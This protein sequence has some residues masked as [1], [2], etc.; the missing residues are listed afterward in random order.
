LY[1]TSYKDRNADK[2]RVHIIKGRKLLSE[3]PSD[4][5]S[6][7][8]QGGPNL[9]NFADY[10]KN[11]DDLLNLETLNNYYFRMEKSIYMD[12]R[13]QYVISFEP[14]TNL[15]YALYYGKLYIDKESLAFTR[16]ET[17]LDMRDR[18][19]VTQAILK[20]KPMGL[21]F[22]PLE[23]SFVVD[24]KEQNGRMALSYVRNEVKFKCDWKK[25]LFHTEYTIVSEMAVT[26]MTDNDVEKISYKESFKDYNS[27]SDK[28][29][30]FYD[31]NYWGAYNII[32]P[33]ESL[34]KAVKKIARQNEKLNDNK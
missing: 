13:L 10:V 20:K 32:A 15:E 25:K 12:N 23:L 11:P 8:L 34:D 1:K 18:N 22:K 6:V 26:D 33:T 21:N 30:S 29:S 9:S 2:D 3:K 27:L 17:S 4:T 28:V 19:K 7:K 5:L 31:E 16:I 14:K 24:Y